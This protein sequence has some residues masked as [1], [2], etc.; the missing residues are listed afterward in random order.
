MPRLLAFD[1]V[2]ERCGAVYLQT[3][4]RHLTPGT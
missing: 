2:A 4:R 3:L 1:V